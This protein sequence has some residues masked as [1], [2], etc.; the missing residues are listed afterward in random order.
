[1]AR[2]PGEARNL[3]AEDPDRATHLAAALA[4]WR[5]SVD[6]QMPAPNPDY[7]PNLQAEDGVVVLPAKTADVEGVML[8]YEPLPHKDTLG[9]WVRADDWAHWDFQ[10][11]EKGTFRVEC[12]VG[13]GNG[14]GG[15]TVELRIGDKVISLVVPETGGFQQFE[16]LA[17]GQV[18]LTEP[19]RYRLEVRATNKPGPAVMDLREVRLIPVAQP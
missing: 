2:D 5:Q 1:L 18:Q 13:C 9:Y 3:A 19:G 10:L 6:A 16:R 7:V 12:L 17:V 4:E 15:S 14:S 8:R 11:N